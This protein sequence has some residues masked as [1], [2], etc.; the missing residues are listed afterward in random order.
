MLAAWVAM[1]CTPALP[2]AHN[3]TVQGPNISVEPF[4]AYYG[5]RGDLRIVGSGLEAPIPVP[6][7]ISCPQDTE[8]PVDVAIQRMCVGGKAYYNSIGQTGGNRCGYNIFSGV[9]VRQ[10]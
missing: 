4:I 9:C 8:T 5:E 2:Q 1:I 10:P 7:H 3:L 6:R